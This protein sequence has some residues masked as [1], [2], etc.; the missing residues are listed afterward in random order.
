MAFT[1]ADNGGAGFIEGG[2]RGRSIAK[3]DESD[4]IAR[5]VISRW[6]GENKS[7]AIEFTPY[8]DLPGE[9]RGPDSA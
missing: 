3:N 7:C 8:P 9:G 1:A 4:L 2:H 6:V 5:D